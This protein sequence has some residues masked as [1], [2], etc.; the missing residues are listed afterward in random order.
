MAEKM[1]MSEAE[2]IAAL[3]EMKAAGIVRR[4]AVWLAHRKAAYT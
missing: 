3:K 4:Y 1:G 2:L